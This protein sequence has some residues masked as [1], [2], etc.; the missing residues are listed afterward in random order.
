MDK[1]EGRRRRKREK[2]NRRGA[3]ESRII[4]GEIKKKRGGFNWVEKESKN[5]VR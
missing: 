3:K 4:I 2:K 5:R 1:R